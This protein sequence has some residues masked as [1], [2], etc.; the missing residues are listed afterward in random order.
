MPVNTRQVTGR[1][2]LHY[3]VFGKLTP[4]EWHQFHLRHA[5]LHM[6]FVLPK[7]R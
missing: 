2:S 3:P 6:S 5:E 7:Q 1:R 4:E